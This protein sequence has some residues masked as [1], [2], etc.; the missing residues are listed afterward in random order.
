VNILG[1]RIFSARELHAYLGSNRDFTN[2]FDYQVES[3][4][5][6]K[7]KDYSELTTKNV[8]NSGIKRGRGRP[9]IIKRAT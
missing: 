8:G 1:R 7:D 2:W 3:C 4:S 6:I 9:A 5:L